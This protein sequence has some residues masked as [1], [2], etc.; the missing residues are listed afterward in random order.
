MT[1]ELE[2][3]RK[4]ALRTRCEE[5]IDAAGFTVLSDRPAAPWPNGVKLMGSLLGDVVSRDGP[6]NRTHYF[7]RVEGARPLPGW[8]AMATAAT[9]GMQG[10]HLYV[11]AEGPGDSLIATCQAAGAGLARLTTANHLEVVCEYGPPSETATTEHFKTSVKAA[12]RKLETKLRLNERR[13]EQSFQDSAVVTTDMS[14]ARRDTYLEAIEEAMIVWRAWSEA[15]S[16]RLDAL[17]ASED[18]G[19]LRLVEE[20]ITRGPQ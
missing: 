17:A 10:V 2:D 6:G 18:A 11:V 3:P 4:T 19:E 7:V 9:F 14:A 13:L 8:I 5:A 20:E 16:E 15:L 12:R 1:A